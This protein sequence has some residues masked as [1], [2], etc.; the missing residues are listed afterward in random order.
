MPMAT[1][2]IR[3]TLSIILTSTEMVTL[4]WRRTEVLRYRYR[5]DLL[6]AQDFGP[7]LLQ[8]QF[9]RNFSRIRH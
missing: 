4:A 8:S 5:C 7:A 9:H 6:V 3:S 1:P 2:R